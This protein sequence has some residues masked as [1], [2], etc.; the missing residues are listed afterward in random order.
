MKRDVQGR[1]EIKLRT[2]YKLIAKIMPIGSQEHSLKC[3]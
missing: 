3:R 2:K 1:G